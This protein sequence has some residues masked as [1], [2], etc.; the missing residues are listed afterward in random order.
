MT[1][2]EEF[3]MWTDPRYGN[4]S[5]VLNYSDGKQRD[6]RGRSSGRGRPQH[7]VGDLGQRPRRC[8][9]STPTT[10]ARSPPARSRCSTS[11]A[12]VVVSAPEFTYQ[13]L[14]GDLR[15]SD[16]ELDVDGDGLINYDEAHGRMIP[17]FWKGVY[18]SETPYTSWVNFLPPDFMTPDSDGDLIVDAL[19]DQDDDSFVNVAEL[20]RA[21]AQTADPNQSAYGQVNP[22]NPCLPAMAIPF[23]D[24]NTGLDT[25]Q[26][27]PT[28]MRHP[29]ISSAR[30]RSTRRRSIRST[31][32]RTSSLRGPAQCGPSSY[33]A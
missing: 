5:P 10:A 31:K 20:S 19:D 22:L 27:S 26:V 17:G 1:L 6:E 12:T 8:A 23:T 24:L 9:S 15:L 29:P 2:R 30:R 7:A 16:D 32:S 4:K 18:T 33:R 25:T 13:D 28:C 3:T 11:T 21:A 14:D